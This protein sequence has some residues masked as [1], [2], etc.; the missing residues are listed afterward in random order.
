MKKSEHSLLKTFT[1][2]TSIPPFYCRGAIFNTLLCTVPLPLPSLEQLLGSS[3]AVNGGGGGGKIRGNKT[4]IRRGEG[5][6]KKRGGIERGGA[7]GGQR[8]RKE[9]REWDSI[10]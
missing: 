10:I 8:R 6:K 9:V 3:R 4:K 1:C 5:E 2:I 7:I